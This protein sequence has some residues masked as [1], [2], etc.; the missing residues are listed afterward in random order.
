[1]T[2]LQK[3]MQLWILLSRFEQ[4]GLERVQANLA[5]ELKNSGIDVSIVSGTFAPGSETLLPEGIPTLEI[6]ANDKW[7]FIP[8]LLRQLRKHKPD[9]VMTT[10]NDVACLVLLF[11]SLLFPGMKVICTQHLSV[12]APW[13]NARGLKWLKHRVLI[14]MMRA[15]W[16][17]A[18]ALVAVCDA[19]AEDMRSALKLHA[20]IHV[21]YNPVVLPGFAQ[22]MQQPIQWPWPNTSVPTLVFSGRL[23]KVKRLDLL[24]EAF[25]KVTRNIAARLLILGEGPEREQILALIEKNDLHHACRLVGHHA[26]PLPWIQASDI[27]ILPSDYEGF[28]NVLVEA[29]ACGVQIIATDCPHG[30]AEILDHGRYGQLVPTDQPEALTHAIQRS[31][32]KAFYVPAAELIQRA[33]AFTLERASSAYLR[34]IQETSNRP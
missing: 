18:D 9:L 21:I 26:N 24:L 17:K 2:A 25:S 14:G 6:A 12:S 34:L 33:N 23:A 5:P 13:K 3:R 19:L 15:L 16:P 22:Q 28:G 27:L 32:S 8:G 7:M 1:M 29:M 10:S 20:P 31:L 30:P 11:R 4:G